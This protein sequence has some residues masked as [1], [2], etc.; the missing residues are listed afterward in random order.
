MQN[1]VWAARIKEEGEF[2]GRGMD[3]TGQT[4]T[5]RKREKLSGSEKLITNTSRINER[6]TRKAESVDWNPPPQ[7]A[8]NLRSVLLQ[9]WASTFQ[10]SRVKNSGTRRYLFMGRRLT[11]SAQAIFYAK[12]L[13]PPMSKSLIPLSTAV[14]KWYKNDHF[15]MRGHGLKNVG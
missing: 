13:L 2:I 7:T 12:S 1:D 11:R 15:N 5:L 4:Q 10:T 6:R 3:I 9:I 14:Q 8:L